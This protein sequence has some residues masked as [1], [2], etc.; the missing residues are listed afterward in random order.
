MGTWAI[1]ARKLVAMFVASAR[2][3]N[4]CSW[5]FFLVFRPEIPTLPFANRSA[6]R[7]Q[8]GFA[9]VMVLLGDFAT[10]IKIADELMELKELLKGRADVSTE[11]LEGQISQLNEQLNPPIKV[12]AVKPKVKEGSPP[13]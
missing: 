4:W 9:F 3:V 8:R 11:K 13:S 6:L 7:P 10:K 1:A 2:L 5:R 12:M